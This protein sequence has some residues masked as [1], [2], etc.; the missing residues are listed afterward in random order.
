MLL[1]LCPEVRCLIYEYVFQQPKGELLGLSRE[2]AHNY[3]YG[4]PNDWIADSRQEGLVYSSNTDRIQPTNSRFLRTCR[5]INGEAT[6]VFYGMNKIIL[7][8]EDNNDIFYWLLDIGERHRHAIRHLEIDWA[9]GVTM[10]SGRK[11]IYD[12]LQRI[13]DMEDSKEGEIQK[14]RQ[15]LIQAAQGFEKKIVSLMVRTLRLVATIRSLVDFGVYMPGE[16][17]GDI[18]DLH[19]ENLYFAKEVF[20]NSTS[21]IHDC[22]QETL[23]RMAGLKTLTI[24]YTKDNVLAERIARVIGVRQLFIQTCPEGTSLALNME[25]RAIWSDSGWRLEGKMARKILRT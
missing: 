4:P 22:I 9:Y 5:L 13:Q 12:I 25:E 18:W 8:A 11:N 2:P 10:E 23:Q 15:Q 3:A 6:P 19:N 16:D 14:R 17:G 24:G 1:R 7:Y 20:S 21:N